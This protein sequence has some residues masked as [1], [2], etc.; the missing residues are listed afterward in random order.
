MNLISSARAAVTNSG[1]RPAP[2]MSSRNVR[3]D[4]TEG[5]PSERSDQAPPESAELLNPVRAPPAGADRPSWGRMF[6]S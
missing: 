2:V 5:P 4:C 3:P 1:G 6:V